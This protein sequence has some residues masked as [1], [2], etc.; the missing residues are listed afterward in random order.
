MKAAVLYGPGQL[1][2]EDLP[3]PL[4]GKGEIVIKVESC[5]IC[6]SD[7]RIYHH[8]HANI[9]LP[10]I[11]GHELAGEVTAIGQ[12]VTAFR[13]G[14]RVAV[15]PAIPCGECYYCRRGQQTVCDNLES[16]GYHYGGGFAEYCRVPARALAQGNV[17]LVPGNVSYD[18]A[19]V[20]EPL[21]CAINAQEIAGVGLG[22]T[23]AVI[24]AGPIGCMHVQLARSLGAT[25]TILVEINAER[26]NIARVAKAD[27]Y[28]DSSRSDPVAA[29]LEATGGHGAD[30][31][32]VSCPSGAAQEQALRMVRKRGRVSFFGG[33]P[34]GKSVI[35]FDSNLVHY[36]EFSVLGAY[37]STPRHNEMALQMIAAGR[38]DLKGIITH[39]VKLEEIERGMN[40]IETGEALK[41][42]VIPKGAAKD[43]KNACG[44]YGYSRPGD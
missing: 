38:I 31:V 27:L 18:E 6:G 17:H 1:K 21:A 2:L 16:I 30:V 3:T 25:K 10:Q 20:A 23:V 5:A 13:V 11:V 33:L 24:G 15:A 29:V 9:K 34:K 8:G 26:L 43:D 12:G 39:R 22:D 42:C 37:G 4:A 40:L 28:V 32:V 7:V 35:Q 19:A 44:H 36:R 41:V 14:D